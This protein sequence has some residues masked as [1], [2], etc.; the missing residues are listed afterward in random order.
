MK[1]WKYAGNPCEV[2]LEASR[3]PEIEVLVDETWDAHHIDASAA[4]EDRDA[5]TGPL[6]LVVRSRVAGRIGQR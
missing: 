2:S 4:T 1:G 3:D 5:L 6:L